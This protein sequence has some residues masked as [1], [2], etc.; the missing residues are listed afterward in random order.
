MNYYDI[1]DRINL[2]DLISI[3]GSN[4]EELIKIRIDNFFEEELDPFRDIKEFNLIEA[5]DKV[6]EN[7]NPFMSEVHEILNDL[8]LE[9]YFDDIEQV[10]PNEEE[11]SKASNLEKLIEQGLS[12]EEKKNQV[13]N[14]KGSQTINGHK[15]I[16]NTIIVL[17]GIKYPLPFVPVKDTLKWNSKLNRPA[18]ICSTNNVNVVTKSEIKPIVIPKTTT[19][20]EKRRSVL[21][22]IKSSL[23]KSSSKTSPNEQNHIG[24]IPTTA[25]EANLERRGNK[26][27]INNRRTSMVVENLPLY[28]KNQLANDSLNED[29]H[30]NTYLKNN[31]K[32]TSLKMNK[33][34]F[35]P[36]QQNTPVSKKPSRFKNILTNSQSMYAH[37]KEVSS[38][39]SNDSQTATNSGYVSD[40]IL[41]DSSNN[42]D[43]V[44]ILPNL[45]A[46]AYE[47]YNDY[48]DEESGKDFQNDEIDFLNLNDSLDDYIENNE[49]DED[50]DEDDK[51]LF[52]F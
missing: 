16:N 41:G 23:F 45:I 30:E 43:K 20:K 18:A 5:Y 28:I 4:N 37:S 36:L 35:K 11:N 24:N 31:D 49:N 15:K 12:G 19:I 9:T 21:E 8:Q 50:E 10:S 29:N 42:E 33:D 48:N 17:E 13:V 3:T 6:N 14:S 27:E 46:K 47:K 1:Y 40:R 38:A 34:I 22:K 25:P 52:R 26:N 2:K 32:S 51:Y 44:Y 39:K 7:E